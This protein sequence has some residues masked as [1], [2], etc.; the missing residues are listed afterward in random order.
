MVDWT[1]NH[2]QSSTSAE[3]LARAVGSQAR[4][5]VAYVVN[6]KELAVYMSSKSQNLAFVSRIEFIRL[7]LSNFLLMYPG[8]GIGRGRGQ[9]TG[10][11]GDGGG[12]AVGGSGGLE[13]RVWTPGPETGGRGMVSVGDVTC[14]ALRRSTAAAAA[15]GHLAPGALSR[16][17]WFV[18]SPGQT[19]VLS[20]SRRLSPSL[21]IRHYYNFLVN[22]S[23]RV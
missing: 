11:D 15:R 21:M 16:Y 4:T 7:K 6:G 18:C 1:D 19:E 9:V 5:H 13:M 23:R 20:E 8:S 14:A 22:G 2:R 10:T 3:R 17:N 12:G